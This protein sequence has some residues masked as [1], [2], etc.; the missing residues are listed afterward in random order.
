MSFCRLRRIQ[1]THTNTDI[2]PSSTY[3]FPPPGLSKPPSINSH[4]SIWSNFQMDSFIA[5]YS[6]TSTNHNH[7]ST[8]LTLNPPA[9]TLPPSSPS[10]PQLNPLIAQRQRQQAFMTSWNRIRGKN[11]Y[12]PAMPSFFNPARLEA[13]Q[14]AWNFLR[15]PA[16]G[17][18]VNERV[19]ARRGRDS[20]FEKAL[21]KL[22]LTRCRRSV[23]LSFFYCSL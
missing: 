18:A 13:P 9:P 22:P 8:T 2:S 21:V 7:H 1:N 6:H 10:P 15:D 5:N 3:P 11:R 19:T 16:C 17:G 20:I 14:C 4:S 12:A 23:S